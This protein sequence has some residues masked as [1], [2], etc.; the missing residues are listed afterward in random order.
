ME[1]VEISSVI[2]VGACCLRGPAS[3]GVRWEEDLGDLGMGREGDGWAV[4]G[5]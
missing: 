5:Y 1:C 2:A 3:A 4:E